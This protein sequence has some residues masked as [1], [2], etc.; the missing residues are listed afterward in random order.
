[1]GAL[2]RFTISVTRFQFDS[3]S[4]RP[5]QALEDWKGRGWVG[6]CPGTSAAVGFSRVPMPRVQSPYSHGKFDGVKIN[7]RGG[8]G[9]S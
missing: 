1:M 6:A 9:I 5:D 2:F 3:V 7:K 8:R 4:V